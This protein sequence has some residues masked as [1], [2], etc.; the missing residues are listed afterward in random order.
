M[1]NSS[2]CWMSLC[3]TDG[4]WLWRGMFTLIA[5]LSYLSTVAQQRTYGL[6][7]MSL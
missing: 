5:L 7:V 1:P 3:S 6:I 2:N 4:S